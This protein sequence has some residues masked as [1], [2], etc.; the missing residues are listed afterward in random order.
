LGKWFLASKM[1]T[2]PSRTGVGPA[3]GNVLGGGLFGVRSSLSD[4]GP[5]RSWQSRHSIC[6]S[7]GSWRA[8]GA[9]STTGSRLTVDVDLEKF[10]D[11][12]NHDVLMG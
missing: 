5:R 11:R 4:L 9:S 8:A 7:S 1:P 3:E 12:V 10:F 6:S 2:C